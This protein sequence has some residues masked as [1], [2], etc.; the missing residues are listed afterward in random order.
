TPVRSRQVAALSRTVL[1]LKGVV[2]RVVEE[3]G[4]L[5]DTVEELRR[6]LE[7]LERGQLPWKLKA[8]TP[9]STPLS[10]A[11]PSTLPAAPVNFSAAASSSSVNP[12]SDSDPKAPPSVWAGP[13][14]KENQESSKWPLMDYRAEDSAMTLVYC[15]AEEEVE[16][17]LAL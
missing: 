7:V 3:N 13:S 12:A 9:S 10:L 8:S 11:D 2:D 4:R 14:T 16:A 5:R 1:E 6:R 15:K 17:A